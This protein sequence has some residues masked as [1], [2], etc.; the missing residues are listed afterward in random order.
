MYV[1]V[2]VYVCVCLFVCE[3]SVYIHVCVKCEYVLP[4][5][6]T[7]TPLT[8]NGHPFSSPLLPSPPLP[9]QSVNLLAMETRRLVRGNHTRKTA[10]FVRACAAFSF[11]TIPSVDN[12][13]T[14]LNLYLLS[15][16]VAVANGA[17]SQGEWVFFSGGLWREGGKEGGREIYREL[18]RAL[19]SL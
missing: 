10:A 1:C 16:R 12:I 11:I 2:Y 13:L 3:V 18:S 8:Q 15:G 17:L 4:L 14:R 9:P 19:C 5:L 7:S 6:P